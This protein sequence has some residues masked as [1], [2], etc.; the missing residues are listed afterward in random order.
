VR[1]MLGTVATI[2]VCDSRWPQGRRCPG[3]V[4]CR[5]C[6]WTAQLSSTRDAGTGEL[7]HRIALVQMAPQALADDA[8]RIRLDRSGSLR[9]RI[10]ALCYQIAIH[11]RDDMGLAPDEYA[12]FAMTFAAVVRFSSG[13][14]AAVGHRYQERQ[15]PLRPVRCRRSPPRAAYTTTDFRSRSKHTGR[16]K[17]LARAGGRCLCPVCRGNG[18]TFASCADGRGQITCTCASA[19]IAAEYESAQD[20]LLEALQASLGRPVRLTIE[21]SEP[22]GETPAERNR[23]E[24]RE[25]SGKSSCRHRGDPF[26]RD[27]MDIFGAALMKRRSKPV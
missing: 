1:D 13:G 16:R 2:T 17:R 23:N 3:H 6:D 18:A 24:K 22:A 12:G 26:V 20:K 15:P 19:Q 14:V 7:F 10:S 27:V 4:G 9:C 11:G 5:R 25:R 8:E 21:L